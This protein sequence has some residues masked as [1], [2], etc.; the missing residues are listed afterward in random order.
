[1]R[2]R[3]ITPLFI[4]AAAI[5]AILNVVLI[6][7]GR[8]SFLH[9]V[10]VM[11]AVV[12]VALPA[13]VISGLLRFVTRRNGAPNR[14]ARV[15][16]AIMCVALSTVVSA[17]AG[18]FVLQR[19]IAQAKAFCE[20]LIP[21]LEQHRAKTLSYPD[22]LESIDRRTPPYLLRSRPY[23]TGSPNAYSFSFDDP[24]GMMNGFAWSSDANRWEEWD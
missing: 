20:S 14:F 6:F 15:T 16:L 12:W 23:Y 10:G 3:H 13:G 11:G 1:M 22:R 18:S 17:V 8:G 9:L 19:D 4:A 7:V 24:G 21:K 5:A 2:S